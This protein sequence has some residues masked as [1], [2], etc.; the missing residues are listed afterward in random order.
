VKVDRFGNLAGF[1]G[2][3][4]RSIVGLEVPPDEMLAR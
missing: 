3:S 1:H 4:P 2:E